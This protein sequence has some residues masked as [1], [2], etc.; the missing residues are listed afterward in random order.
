MCC[1]TKEN[2]TRKLYCGLF[3]SSPVQSHAVGS[4]E[5]VLRHVAT[6]DVY[7]NVPRDHFREGRSSAD[8]ARARE[9][10]SLHGADAAHRLSN[11]QRQWRR[12][13]HH[14]CRINTHTYTHITTSN[15]IINTR[16]SDFDGDNYTHLAKIGLLN[17]YKILFIHIIS[18]LKTFQRSHLKKNSPTE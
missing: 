6:C 2:G 11:R 18:C 16:N 4:V 7:Q 3:C 10:C 9:P 13:R 17:S 8:T 5:K 14:R 1:D 15:N 12:R